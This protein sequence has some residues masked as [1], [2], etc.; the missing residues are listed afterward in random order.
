MP[1][2]APKGSRQRRR[3][4]SGSACRTSG[5]PTT[6]SWSTPREDEY[7]RIFEAILTLA[8]VGARHPD[9]APGHER[10]RRSPTSGG[11]AG[12]GAGDARRAVARPGHRRSRDR[13]EPDRVRESRDE[14]PV[15]RAR[16]LSRRDGPAV[17]SPVGRCHRPRSAAVFTTS[18]TSSSSRS[19]RRAP[20]CRSGSAGGPSRPS[21]GPAGSATATTRARHHPPGM[22]SASP[23]IRDAAAAAGR[24]MLTL[25]ARVRI[26]PGVP[27]TGQADYALRGTP[28]EIRAGSRRL[29][30]HRRRSPGDLLHVGHARDHRS[31]RGVVRAGVPAQP[32]T[33]RSEPSRARHRVFSLI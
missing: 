16:R 10:H 7:G 24:P 14:R 5:R 18:R 12:Q 33:E 26:E 11:R 21:N 3:R 4:P 13:L 1:A 30:G 20:G 29:A 15:P 32:L 28:D 31:R 8:H 25:S 23:V 6:S 17:A 27:Q 19:R 9:A 22:A 2:P